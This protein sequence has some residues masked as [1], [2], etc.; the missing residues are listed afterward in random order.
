MDWIV[1]TL[2][3]V[4]VLSVLVIAH[5]WG[6]FIVAKM[7]GM[8][9]EDFSLF[10]GPRI[11]R[12]GKY[13][14]TEYNVRSIPLGG[15]VKIA[16]MEPDD[17]VLGAALLRPSLATDK[18][19]MMHGL[20]EDALIE[21]D[22][23]QIGDRVR[24]LAEGA[25]AIGPRKRLSPEGREELKSLLTSTSIN[26]EEH[27]YLEILLK[28]DDYQPDP[29]GY[30]QRPL[31]QRAAVIVAGPFMSL[32]FGLLLFTV[33]GFTTGLPYDGRLENIIDSVSDTIDTATHQKPPAYR[34]GLLAG[35]RIIQIEQT[36]ITN[37]K[38]M[39]EV[40]RKNPGNPL[41]ITVQRGAVPHTFLVTPDAKENAD[42]SKD[43][44][45]IIGQIGITP[46][47]TLL[48]RNYSPIGSVQ[49]GMELF[50]LNVKMM[51]ASIFSKDVAKNTHGIIG[52]AGQIH[53]DS[54]A[55][56]R[57]V[58]LDAASLSLSLG[59]INLFPI[60]ILDGGHLLLLG[61]EGLRRRKLTSREV[62]AAQL[63]GFSIIIV[64]FVLVTCK[65]FIEGVLPHLI[66]HG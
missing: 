21:L 42:K 29:K 2:Y 8:H 40:L 13:K 7:C 51:L 25:V 11:W 10:F 39:V 55:G 56:V 53:E 32:L 9:V 36:P 16:G 33:M 23:N 26:E 30:N 58:L 52:I 24:A 31:W 5:E 6:H 15:F 22:A 62:M 28:A 34:A 17:L 48:F 45:K 61:W 63:F 57:H 1:S 37:G 66:R 12:I 50:T 46:K 49:R 54:K 27:K 20:S 18:P 19:V 43:A 64:L 3:I 44:P 41:H 38:D 59:V 65:D 35:D 60:P 47:Y 4:G 14:G